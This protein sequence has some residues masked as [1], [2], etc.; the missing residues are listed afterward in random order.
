MAPETMVAAVAQNTKLNTNKDQSVCW[1]SN[2]GPFVKSIHPMIPAPV[3]F[4]NMI[5]YPKSKK[6]TVP[7][8]K[9][10][11]FFIMIFPAFFRL[12]NPAST[13]ANPACMKK[14][15]AAPI[16]YQMPKTCDNTS[17]ISFSLP[18]DMSY[19]KA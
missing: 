13:I 11:K 5:E 7:K 9:S 6:A 8:Q 3:S 4:P 1:K 10:I 17:A 12:V 18:F 19:K 16:R 15:S 2:S 14:T